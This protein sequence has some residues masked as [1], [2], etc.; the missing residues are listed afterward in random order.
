[1]KKFLLLFFIPTLFLTSLAFGQSG[2]IT[3][4]IMDSQTEK[5]LPYCNVFLI[6]TGFGAS[7]AEDGT[8]TIRDIPE[9]KYT[10][11]VSYIG[12]K[13]I[14]KTI[15]VLKNKTIEINFQ[16]LPESLKGEEV[17]VTAQAV[18]QQ[19][20]INE[21]LNSLSVKNVVSS[22]RIQ[23]LPDANAAE[24]VSRLPGISLIR[25]G[26]EGSQ[27]V[28]RGLSPQYNQITID[29]VELPGNVSSGPD[30]RATDL[31]LISSNMLGSIEVIKAITPDM[32]AAVLGGVVNFGMRKAA[33]GDTTPSFEIVAQGSYNALKTSYN[34]YKF[35]GSVEKR[36]LG[37][38][39]GVFIQGN[40]EEKDL[41]DNEL[42][43]NY[44]LN[45]KSRGDTALPVLNYMTLTDVLRTRY[46]YGGT[47]T[48]DYKHSTGEIDFMNFLSIGDT[49]VY[50]RGES[51]PSDNGYITYDAGD[52][53]FNLTTFTNLLSIKQKVSVLNADIKLSHSYSERK[54]P[55]STN[56]EFLQP[57]AVNP[58]D[59]PELRKLPPQELATFVQHNPA[60]G[61]L[62][63]ITFSNSISE[64][65]EY[66]GSIDLQTDFVLSNFVTGKLKFGGMYQ[67]STRSYNYDYWFGSMFDDGQTV[68]LAM[69]NQLGLRTVPLGSGGP[70]KTLDYLDF[71]DNSYNYHNFFGGAYNIG[72]PANVNLILQAS[73]IARANAGTNPAQVGFKYQ[74]APSKSA[75]YSGNEIKDALYGMFVMNL[76]SNI[77]IIPGVR[78]QN[79]TTDYNGIRGQALIA[80][81]LQYTNSNEK[82][83]HGYYLP[84]VHLIYRPIAGIQLHFAYTNTLNYPAYYNIIPSYLINETSITYH[85]FRL[86]PARSENFDL[87]FSVFNN[88][89]GLFTIDGFN[90]NIRDLIFSTGATYPTVDQAAKDY[91][92][93][94]TQYLAGR[95]FDTY[96][97][98]PNTIQV[99][100]VEV[101]WQTHFWYLPNPLSGLVLNVNYTHIF[102]DAKYPRTERVSLGYDPYT[103]TEKY[104]YIDTFYTARLLDQPKDIFNISAGYDYKGFSGRFSV[105]Y[106]DNVFKQPS[107]W[108]QERIHSDKYL[109]F[110]LS[111]KQT[112][113]WYRIQLYFN[114]NNITG[115]DDVDLN[116]KTAYPA[117]SQRYGMTGD[118]GIRLN[119]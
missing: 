116:E 31:S 46:R 88:E 108:L 14:E 72:S 79:L 96:I 22:D 64:D 36:F 37:E 97:N 45:D 29:G 6:S 89:V 32:D 39:L 71:I 84:M 94:P 30:D 80:G 81:R 103:G 51:Y 100:G 47:I 20:A 11:R 60:A 67:Y 109:R 105:Y 117:A 75:N 2:S 95:E 82:L 111:V 93:F 19:H 15:Q 7:A 66:T 48:M 58:G 33:I 112:L 5:P 65:N 10:I 87:A 101:D 107:F 1:M 70:L 86:K 12:Y 114:L 3:G 102:S 25:T 18:G 76:G 119:L 16:M 55:G 77:T 54:A 68:V 43:V 106:Q 85:N 44:I 9:G 38:K 56:F 62:Q 59:V 26:G 115:V 4:K 34:N 35:V 69:A 98:N 52:A 110:D 17:V 23:A 113:P 24:S 74:V 27:V 90:K 61:Y 78:Y 118:L 42:G 8:Y 83:S 49:K 73:N 50:N 13:K 41:S 104:A 99:Y 57:D 28:V 40:I 92:E 53:P 63:S 21:Q 91:P